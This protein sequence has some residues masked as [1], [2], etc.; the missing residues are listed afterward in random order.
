MTV[1]RALK[2][3]PDVLADDVDTA[4]QSRRKIGEILGGYSP[5]QLDVLF[6]YFARASQAYREAA[7]PG[8]RLAPP[9]ALKSKVSLRP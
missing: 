8:R 2:Y 5:E 7:E 1:R 3:R 4:A 6:D 9:G